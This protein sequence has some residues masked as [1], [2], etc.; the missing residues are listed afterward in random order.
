MACE[1]EKCESVLH[2][3]KVYTRNCEHSIQEK[4]KKKEHSSRFI[5]IRIILKTNVF[6]N[7]LF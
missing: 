5:N 2:F 3:H 1:R 4:K 7:W 6:N